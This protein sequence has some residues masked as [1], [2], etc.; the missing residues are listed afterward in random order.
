MLIIAGVVEWYTRWIQNPLPQGLRV[1]V[2]PPAPTNDTIASMRQFRIALILLFVFVIGTPLAHAASTVEDATVNIYCT[3]QKGRKT[4]SSTGSGVFISERGVILTNAHVAQTLLIP[5]GKK[6][7][8]GSCTIRTGSPARATYK[9]SL[10]YLSDT[11]V[12]DNLQALADKNP[13]GTGEG[14][15]ALL[16]VTDAV[17]GTLPTTFPSL[18]P[19]TRELT[20]SDVGTLVT[21]S[22]Y[23]AGTKSFKTTEKRLPFQSEVVTVENIHSFSNTAPDILTLSASRVAAPGVSGG[24]ITRPDN[25]LIGIAAAVEDSKKKSERRMRAVSL[26][27]MNRSLINEEGVSLY[28]LLL[29]DLA[30]R[31]STTLTT[32]SE[33]TRTALASALFK[34]R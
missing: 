10:L 22:G 31:A 26:S 20:E 28:S 23:P 32:F 12:A 33:E 2:S 25:T 18:F 4:Y 24:P 6:A 11:W 9:A 21:E 15:F 27:H 3:F 34:R 5:L 29:G 8:K 19:D 14:D 30:L 7:P 17:G 13:K 1:R 16:Y